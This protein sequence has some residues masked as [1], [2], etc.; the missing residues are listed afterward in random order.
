MGREAANKH[1]KGSK[2]YREQI[3]RDSKFADDH[4]NLPYTFS[5]PKKYKNPTGVEDCPSCG[6]ASPIWPNTIMV[7]CRCGILYRTD[8]GKKRRSQEV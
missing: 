4:K 5:K 8:K 2:A 1:K 3:H 7:A 6:N